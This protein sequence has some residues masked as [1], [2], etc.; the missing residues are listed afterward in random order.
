MVGSIIS[1]IVGKGETKP[2]LG[3]YRDL[4]EWNGGVSIITKEV[5]GSE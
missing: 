4:F 2:Y 5:G 1:G 3:R